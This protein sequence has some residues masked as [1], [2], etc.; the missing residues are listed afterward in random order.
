M[1]E[2]LNEMETIWDL[3]LESQK[4]KGFTITPLVP[5]LVVHKFTKKVK[6]L[7]E[8]SIIGKDTKQVVEY[9]DV[10]TRSIEGMTDKA[11]RAQLCEAISDFSNATDNSSLSDMDISDP[12]HRQQIIQHA[13][14]IMK[15]NTG[16]NVHEALAYA[17][18]DCEPG[19]CELNDQYFA[20]VEQHFNED[21]I[22]EVLRLAKEDN[23]DNL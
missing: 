12:E 14:N 15:M 2:L 18:K 10:V 8:M 21:E 7:Q 6:Q 4:T 16:C 5:D 19:D 23:L 11:L 13:A 1:F 17:M 20:H 22:E 3:C 9:L